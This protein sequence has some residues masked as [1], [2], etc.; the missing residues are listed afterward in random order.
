MSVIS[1]LFNKSAYN[2]EDAFR[3]KDKTSK[4]MQEAI[5]DWFDLYYIT[6]PT[7]DEDPC[8]QIPYT[9]VRK[10]TKTTFSEYK[11]SSK[12]EFAVGVLES[13]DEHK[14]HAVELGLIGGECLLKPVPRPDKKGF[15]WAMIPRNNVL[16]FARDDSGRM[17]DIGMAGYATYGT[18]FYT[19]LER[20]TVDA[21]GYL[22]IRNKLYRSE[23]Q[24]TLGVPVQLSALPQYAELPEEYTFQKPI[25]SVGLVS[26]KAPIAN[27]VDGSHDGVSVYAAAAGLIH[28]IN[29]NEAQ[30][31]T[32]FSNGKSRV[33]VSAD[34]TRRDSQGRRVF[35]DD[36]FVGVDGDPEDMGVTVFSPALREAS[37]LARKQEYLR[38]VESVIGLKRGLLSEV[39]AAERTAKEITSSEGDY[40]LT[41]IDFQQMWEKAAREAVELCGVLGQMYR[42]NG[43]HEVDGDAVT[44]DWGNGVLFDEEKTWADYVAMVAAGLLKPEIALGWKFGMPTETE[45]DLKK[46]R[47]K[48]MPDIE[49]MARDGG[50]E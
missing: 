36:I 2:Y 37:F 24:G 47:E 20:R 50:E 10:L 27:C 31:N 4:Q 44:F 49:G 14:N 12:D 11:A 41:V 43:A 25:G 29:R 39:E 15:A 23:T 28:N 35:N 30:L 3:A 26:M 48:F 18:H 32:E 1:A 5:I 34:L 46:I 13:L 21:R 6:K 9:I 38:N 8:Q 19:L 16:V 17:T 45:A 7:K 22:T 42:I 40:N 33:F